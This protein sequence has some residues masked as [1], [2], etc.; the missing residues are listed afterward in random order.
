MLAERR[1]AWSISESTPVKTDFQ[2]YTNY[3]AIYELSTE[4]RDVIVEIWE[5]GNE[6]KSKSRLNMYLVN[7]L[8]MMA[9]S[10]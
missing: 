5:E 6:L 9:R 3:E 2:V 8:D 1:S 10:L 4:H 7:Y